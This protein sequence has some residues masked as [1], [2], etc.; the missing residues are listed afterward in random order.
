MYEL[1]KLLAFLLFVFF[2]LAL[3]PVGWVIAAIYIFAILSSK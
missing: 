3:G 1:M 2:L